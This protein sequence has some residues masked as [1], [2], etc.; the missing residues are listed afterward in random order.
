MLSVCFAKELS[1][2]EMEQL[3]TWTD[4]CVA[5]DGK[6]ASDGKPLASNSTAS[7]LHHFRTGEAEPKS[8]LTKNTALLVMLK[9]NADIAGLLI[10][11]VAAEPVRIHKV[12][13]D[14]EYRSGGPKKPEVSVARQLKG[15]FVDYCRAEGLPQIVLADVA[16]VRGRRAPSSILG[17][18]AL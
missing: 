3:C 5:H 4:E 9:L 12:L 16:C 1:P 6:A 8:R 11:E 10:A 18:K 2:K 17:E 13:V 15:R 7:M 14:P